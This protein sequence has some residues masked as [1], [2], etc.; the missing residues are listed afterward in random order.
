MK[1]RHLMLAVVIVASFLAGTLVPTA[2]TQ[3]KTV[4]YVEVD[5]MK[6]EPGK[7]ADY[8]K[9]EQDL[10]KPVHQ[11]RVKNGKLK[12][13]SLYALQ[14]PSGTDEKY[15]FVTVNVFD[16]FGQLENPYANAEEL[17]AKVHPGMKLSD[18]INRTDS[19]RRLVRSEVWALIDH[20]E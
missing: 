5:Y 14:F 19:A 13:W 3:S 20:L 2:S 1:L 4:K 17:L 16:Q 6:V 15:D 11:E 10:W 9:V 8:L 18:F 12:S 7:E